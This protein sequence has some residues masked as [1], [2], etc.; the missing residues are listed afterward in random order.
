MAGPRSIH[1]SLRQ[2]RNQQLEH[3]RCSTSQLEDKKS[4]TV[5]SQNKETIVR[6]GKGIGAGRKRRRNDACVRPPTAMVSVSEAM[7][8]GKLLKTGGCWPGLL[9]Q[10]LPPRFLPLGSRREE[11]SSSLL[12]LLLQLTTNEVLCF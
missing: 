6:T 7:A 3:R 10:W 4:A 5:P 9:F 11:A 12:E 1:P 8:R 2:I